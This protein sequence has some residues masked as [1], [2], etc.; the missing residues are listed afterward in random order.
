MKKD[1]ISEIRQQLKALSPYKAIL[2]GSRA[3]EVA[4]AES[5]ID[6]VIV[7]D[8]EGMPKSF[9]ER[10]K[11][12]SRVRSQLRSINREVPMDVLVYTKAEWHKL[13]ELNTSFAREILRTGKAIL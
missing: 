5:D 11:N 12:H 4:T 6:L 7:L 1:R 2:F 13:I 3:S 10:M 8:V 9:S